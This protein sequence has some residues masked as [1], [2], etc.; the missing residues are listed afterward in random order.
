[1]TELGLRK[2]TE[3]VASGVCNLAEGVQEGCETVQEGT[4][5]GETCNAVYSVC[6]A[7]E[8]TPSD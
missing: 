5:G 7:H 1:M 6:L 8:T 2:Q 3:E 4:F